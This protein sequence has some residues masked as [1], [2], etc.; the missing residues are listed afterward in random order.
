MARCRMIV[1]SAA[2]L[3]LLLAGDGMALTLTNWEAVDQRLQISEGG[4]ETV[5]YDI[6]ISAHETLVELCQDGCTIS[7]ENGEQQSFEGSEEVSIED[8]RFVILE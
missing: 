5:T 4:D 3:A 7:L 6:V 8:G 2:I 1:L